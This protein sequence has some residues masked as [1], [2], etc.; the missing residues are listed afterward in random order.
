MKT[1]ADILEIVNKDEIKQFQSMAI[2]H[3]HTLTA[4]KGIVEGAEHLGAINIAWNNNEIGLSVPIFYKVKEQ[5]E[6]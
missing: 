6:Q 1:D 5:E 2:K 3:G 4:T